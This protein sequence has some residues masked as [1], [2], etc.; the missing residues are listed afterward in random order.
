MENMNVEYEKLQKDL[1]TADLGK[2][3][4]SGENNAAT[5][6]IHT[7][8]SGPTT[9][10]AAIASGENFVNQ[11]KDAFHAALKYQ[12]DPATP[13]SQKI[14]WKIALNTA[15]CT[16]EFHSDSS[17]VFDNK[18]MVGI[19]LGEKETRKGNGARLHATGF[20]VLMFIMCISDTAPRAARE[21]LTRLQAPLESM[22][23]ETVRTAKTLLKMILADIDRPAPLPDWASRWKARQRHSSTGESI[24]QNPVN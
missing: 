13:S 7:K 4:A 6:A 11:L 8:H 2:I 1:K 19:V 3:T 16:I 15:N 9:I 18:T 22:S 17:G 10:N 12:Q 14:A 24:P 5:T 21:A 23:D 20:R